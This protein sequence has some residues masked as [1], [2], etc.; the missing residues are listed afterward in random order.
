MAE[1][2]I[3]FVKDSTGRIIAVPFSESTTGMD[4]YQFCGIQKGKP[5]DSFRL[6]FAGRQILA[7]DDLISSYNI[8]LHSTL[9]YVE[10]LAG[11]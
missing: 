9:H 1:S 5:T 6:L 8:Q 11:N 10:R 7:G 4:L 3:V 2:Q